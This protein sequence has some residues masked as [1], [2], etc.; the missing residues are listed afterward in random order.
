[1]G[2]LTTFKLKLVHKSIWDVS[3]ATLKLVF[4][5]RCPCACHQKTYTCTEKASWVI[6]CRIIT[7]RPKKTKE[8]KLTKIKTLQ[9]RKATSHHLGLIFIYMIISHQ[10]QYTYLYTT[11]TQIIQVLNMC[12][13]VS[14]FFSFFKP[15]L[16]VEE[17]PIVG[18]VFHY[19]GQEGQGCRSGPITALGDLSPL[20]PLI[21]MKPLAYIW[22]E[23]MGPRGPN[24]R[25][26]FQMY[27]NCWGMPKQPKCPASFYHSKKKAS[28][29]FFRGR[30]AHLTFNIQTRAGRKL[31]TGGVGVW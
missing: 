27:T 19:K 11:G 9:E 31:L 25:Q 4:R 13:T 2:Y 30:A 20:P 1:M 17:E 21:H 22:T 12:F 3:S 14:F 5:P 26:S 24:T 15:N 28:Y 6:Q 16:H 7:S 10:L 23:C 29:S 18:F 8:T